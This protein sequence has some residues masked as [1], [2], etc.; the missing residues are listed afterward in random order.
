LSAEAKPA[1]HV[2]HHHPVWA[3]VGHVA[4]K[5]GMAAIWVALFPVELVASFLGGTL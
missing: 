1:Q 3:R 4:D 2:K 5:V